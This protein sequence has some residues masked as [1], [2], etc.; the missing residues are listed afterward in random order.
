MDDR[1]MVSICT[2][3]YASVGGRLLHAGYD[4][5]TVSQLRLY[6]A[7]APVVYL[8]FTLAALI[9]FWL[10]V[11]GFAFVPIFYILQGVRQRQ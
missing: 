4:S 11:I 5:K 8:T 10:S 9:N 6:S 2:F 7:V 3:W 1:R